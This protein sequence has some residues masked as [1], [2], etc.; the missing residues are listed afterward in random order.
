MGDL[1]SENWEELKLICDCL[2]LESQHT[3]GGG[4]ASLNIDGSQC[5][6][7]CYSQQ[8][9]RRISDVENKDSAKTEEDKIAN[10]I[11]WGLK[12]DY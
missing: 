5:L 10:L 1:T 3:S 12:V 11:K 7:D 2:H 4:C 6:C 8:K 9:Y